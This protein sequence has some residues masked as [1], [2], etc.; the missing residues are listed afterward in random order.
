MRTALTLSQSIDLQL[1]RKADKIDL[2]GK[3]SFG[4]QT[5]TAGS[6][7]FNTPLAISFFNGSSVVA[8]PFGT[9]VNQIAA[10]FLRWRIAK[11][12]VV[13]RPVLGTNS[14]GRVCLAF[15]DDNSREGSALPLPT[16]VDE[17]MDLRC[18]HVDSIYR[19]IEVPF[20]PI[21]PSKLYYTDATMVGASGT[22]TSDPRFSTPAT[23]VV[24]ADSAGSGVTAVAGTL[25]MYYTLSFEGAIDPLS[26]TP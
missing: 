14:A 3:V 2:K 6:L 1:A 25:E 8:G 7:A 21:D 9:R 15:L 12:L 23:L 20:S 19:D 18:S 26:S 24:N 13:W 5:V 4:L 17:A 10:C 11:L 22:V 16:G